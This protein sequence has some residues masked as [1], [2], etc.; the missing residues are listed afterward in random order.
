[1]VR[2][3]GSKMSKSK[4]NLVAPED[5]IDTLGADTLRL[6]H[7]AVKPPE[8]NVDWEDFGLDGCSRFLARVWRLAVPGTDLAVG[9]GPASR[10]RSTRTSCAEPTS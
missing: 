8:E 6:A 1:M 7:L 4:G 3:G 10:V 5:I 9:V 2:L